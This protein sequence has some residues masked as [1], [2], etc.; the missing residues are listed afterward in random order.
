MAQQ[1][2]PVGIGANQI[3][4]DGTQFVRGM[5]SSDYANDGGFGSS[6]VGINP[7]VTPGVIYATASATDISTNVTGEIIATA[8]DSQSTAAYDRLFVDASAAFYTLSSTTITKRHT[9]SKT[10][11]FGTT[12]MVNFNYV[13]YVTSGTDVA[14][15][16]TS[17]LS[18]DETWW[19]VTKSK[20]ALTSTN[21]HPML[22]YEQLLWIADGNA[23]WNVNTSATVTAANW[24][25][26]SGE[27]ITALGIDPTTGL[28]LVAVTTSQNYSDAYNARNFVYLYDGYSAKPRRK[29]PVEDMITSFHVVGSTLYVGYGTSVGYWTGN[30]VSFLRR[31]ANASL[32]GATLPY[33]HHMCNINNTLFVADG[34]N[35]LAY[36][37][38]VPGQK[39]FY[40]I[41]QGGA[42]LYAICNIG[43]SK[44][45]YA[46]A[47]ATIKTVDITS[48]SAG[49][50]TFYANNI[51][52]PRPVWLRRMRVFT[53][54]ITT[55]GGSGIGGVAIIDDKAN[56]NQ[57]ATVTFK[58]SSGTKYV[59][60]FDFMSLKLQMAQ[61]RVGID[62]QGFGI[63]RIIL[64]YDV[65]E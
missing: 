65:A 47:S 60:D 1:K 38:I 56:S 35:V 21:R 64:Y 7:R 58:N 9:G 41:A 4:L 34:S 62:T 48:K 6:S 15:W 52:F 20:T 28:M 23:L 42:S 55:T 43:N 22:V 54:G 57:P 49:V 44:L 40:Y 53:T 37:E 33:K 32:S 25:L 3:Q 36:G 19:T 27:F 10:Y 17:S 31:L 61:P 46:Y 30:G 63:I 16:N 39:G 11:T 18:L 59:F 14:A 26:V 8:E 2:L 13:T 12:D 24:S 45:A 5:A 29:I 51:N 50:A